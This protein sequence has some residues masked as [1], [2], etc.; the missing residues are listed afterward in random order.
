[1]IKNSS[2]LVVGFFLFLISF[3]I[4]YDFLNGIE[5]HY[6]EAQY[7]VWSQNPSLSYLT[8][9]PFVA[10][11]ISLSNSIFGQSYLG[12]KFFSL[13]AYVGTIIFIAYSSIVLKKDKNIGTTALLITGLSPALFFLG[14]VASTDAYLFFF[15]SLVLF[16]YI[17]FTLNKDVRWFYFIAIATGLGLLTKLSMALLPISILIYF[18]FTEYRKYFYSIHLY[19]SAL[20][21]ILIASPIVIWNIDN[22]W[23]TL[24]HEM[25]HLVSGA[26]SNNPEILLMTM[27]V[28]IPS[29]ALLFKRDIRAKIFSKE[30]SFLLIPFLI[31]FSFF[32]LKSFSGKIQLNWT[33]PLFL[34]LIPLLSYAV[35]NK[36]KSVI[37]LSF[38]ILSPIFLL[39]NKQI[40][41]LFSDDDPLH[42]MRGWNQT[43]EYLFKDQTYNLLSSS[44]YKLLSTAAYFLGEAKMLRL[45]EDEN[46]RL[47]HYDLWNRG[48]AIKQNIL[49]ITYS[50]KLPKNDSMNCVFLRSSDILPRKRISLYN[51]TSK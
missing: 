50:D 40:S 31:M 16:G 19:F 13:L 33:I 1:M 4:A 46:R 21:A 23:L 42:P 47:T 24:S 8:K 15:W 26:P 28:T 22:D 12:L 43:Y 7:W 25:G 44:D 3:R 36:T 38:F 2:V 11:I 45:E 48:E 51:C 39:S 29:A 6:E 34:T 37:A 14:G 35:N 20:L 32:V 18:L 5:Y 17:K 41:S 27:I 49:H 10:S 30:N 9:G